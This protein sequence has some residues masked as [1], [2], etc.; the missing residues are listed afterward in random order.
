MMEYGSS[1][2]LTNSLG[3]LPNKARALYVEAGG[4][5]WQI[6]DAPDG[7]SGLEVRLIDGVNTALT[8]MPRA[9]NDIVVTTA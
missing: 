1:D 2:H 3:P 5:R 7:L 4:H 8:V 9:S 6:S